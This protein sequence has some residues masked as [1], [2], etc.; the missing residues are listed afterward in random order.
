MAGELAA[1]YDPV[2]EAAQSVCMALGNLVQDGSP[3]ALELASLALELREPALLCCCQPVG[4]AGGLLLVPAGGDVRHHLGE[5]KLGDRVFF[6]FE[7]GQQRREGCGVLVG[8]EDPGLLPPDLGVGIRIAGEEVGG[9]PGREFLVLRHLAL[10]QVQDAEEVEAVFFLCRGLGKQAFDNLLH[11]RGLRVFAPDVSRDK[12][13][14]PG[15][16]RLVL[17]SILDEFFCGAMGQRR[18]GGVANESVFVIEPGD[19]LAAGGL[20]SEP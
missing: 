10:E 13:S 9:H 1:G 4:K 15:P 16:R 11:M 14:H 8:A 12:G 6:S 3:E 19:Q 5:M 18:H 20:G 17:E 2:G 7:H